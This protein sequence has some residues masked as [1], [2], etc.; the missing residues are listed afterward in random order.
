VTVA[1]EDETDASWTG[2]QL[3]IANSLWGQKVTSLQPSFTSTLSSGYDAPLQSADF[4]DDPAAAAASINAW[5]SQ[6]TSGAIPTLLQPGDVNTETRFVLVDALYFKGTWATG[7][8]PALTANQAFTLADGTQV[9]VPTMTG[10]VQ[11]SAA[12]LKDP[13]ATVYELPYLGD[14]VAMDLIVPSGSLASFEASLTPEL[15]GQATASLGS[16]GGGPLSMPKFSFGTRVALVPVLQGLGMTD[17]FEEGVANLSGIDGQQDLFV[18]TVVQQALVEV[19]ESGTVAAAATATA[20]GGGALTI[21]PVAI[22]SP[23]L[24]LIRDTKNGSILFMGHV[25]DPR[26]S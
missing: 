2:D 8:D 14:A 5:V 4:A 15:L 24:F 17:A 18:Q 10:N 11:Y 21:E 7:F 12:Y 3:A 26:A 9:Q 20:G 25:L 1:C 23:F 6:Q 16:S 22:A 13:A 19:D